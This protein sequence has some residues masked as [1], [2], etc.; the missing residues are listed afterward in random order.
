MEGMEI[1]S[2]MQ[3]EGKEPPFILCLES[4]ENRGMA[5]DPEIIANPEK[6]KTCYG[7]RALVRQGKSN[8]EQGSYTLTTKGEIQ[9]ANHNLAQDIRKHLFSSEIGDDCLEKLAKSCDQLEQAMN[10]MN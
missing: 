2:E 7:S 8:Q 9:R 3:D 4:V 6:L 10:R 5:F 1:W